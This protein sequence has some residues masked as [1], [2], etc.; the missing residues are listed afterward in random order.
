M[1][2]LGPYALFETETTPVKSWTTSAPRKAPNIGSGDQQ[3]HNLIKTEDDCRLQSH[4]DCHPM[5]CF[6]WHFFAF[7]RTFQAAMRFRST[8]PPP[9]GTPRSS[10]TA[11]TAT[12]PVKAENAEKMISLSYVVTSVSKNV[13]P[14]VPLRP[15]KQ[16]GSGIQQ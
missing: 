2:E 6:L 8:T 9:T 3:D 14:C 12:Q 1:L 15:E 16:E 7:L 10:R 5:S 11:A 13:L 4:A